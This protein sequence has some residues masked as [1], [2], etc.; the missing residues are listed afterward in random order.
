MENGEGVTPSRLDSLISSHFSILTSPF[1]IPVPHNGPRG[2]DVRKSL[3]WSALVACGASACLWVVAVE[4]RAA[5]QGTGVVQVVPDRAA[6]TEWLAGFR[7]DALKNGISQA[8]LD[9]AL[10]DLEPLPIVIERDRTQAEHV[11]ALDVYLKRRLNPKT[12]KTA[13]QMAAQ[14]RAVLKRVSSTYGV[15][16]PVVVSVWGLESTF[17]RFTG[18]RPTIAALATLAHDNRRAAMFRSE[19]LDALRIVEAGDIEPARMTGS[20]AGAM[21]QP[22]FMP[23]SYRKYA[24]DFDK[25]GRRDIWQS[26]PDAFASI[27]NYLKE[28]GWRRGERWGRAVRVPEAAEAKIAEAAPLRTEGCSA[29]RAMTMPLTVARWRALG[30]TTEGRKALPKSKVTASLV[31]AGARSFLVYQNY[32]SLLGYNCAH[33]YAL[34]VALL[35]D[36]VAGAK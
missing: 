17:G 9:L 14:N 12:V 5:R 31:R 4:A 22:Q 35:S 19:L 25:D 26:R 11:L 13:R 29:E 30:V 20:W 21:G 16:P 33:A 3:L 6:F 24:V 34:S 32:E 36:R 15:P 27:A 18:T 1:S 28:Q 2:A 23:S 8:T 7:Q 10:A